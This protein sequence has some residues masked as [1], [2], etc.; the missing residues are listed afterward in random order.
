MKFRF[1][2]DKLLDHR[3]TLKEIA[4]K[5]YILAQTAVDE[6]EAKLKTMYDDVENARV[7]AGDLTKSGGAQGAALVQINEFIGGQKFRIER[8]REEIRGLR[9]TAEEKQLA[10]VEAAK[11]HKT[12]VKLKER[13][14]ADY[15]KLR[16]KLELKEMDEIV[17]T[18][19]K[20]E[21]A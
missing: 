20:R 5:E 13:R 6:A 9:M 7:R 10:L 2:Y 12:L 21:G 14:L 17:T 11:E 18:R 1:P 8:Q 19:F 4:H 3:K 15:K 16:K